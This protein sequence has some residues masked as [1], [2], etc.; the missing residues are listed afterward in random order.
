M[1]Q[2]T[3]KGYRQGAVKH[4]SQLKN[5]KTGHWTKRGSDGRFMDQKADS[6]PFKGIT[7]ED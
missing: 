7:K 2:N 5:T 3:G 1:A 6:N 4:R